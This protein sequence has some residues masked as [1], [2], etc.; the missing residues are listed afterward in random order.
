MKNK[1]KLKLK[2]K[3]VQIKDF[4][5]TCNSFPIQRI[6]D[7]REQPLFDSTERQCRLLTNQILHADIAN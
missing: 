2:K 4:A 3:K 6:V 7:N 5:T 1:R